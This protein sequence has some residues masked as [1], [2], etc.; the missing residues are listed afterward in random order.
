MLSINSVIMQLYI[1]FMTIVTGSMEA[2]LL[3]AYDSANLG[4]ITQLV[5]T[6]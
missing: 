1:A 3:C 4:Y 2:G 6:L 5:C